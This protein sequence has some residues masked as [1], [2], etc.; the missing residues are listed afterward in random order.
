MRVSE[1]VAPHYEPRLFFPGFIECTV[2]ARNSLE[3]S[4]LR[5][6]LHARWFTLDADCVLLR[7]SEIELSENERRMVAEAVVATGGLFALSDR[8]ALYGAREWE[9]YDDL[10]RRLDHRVRDIHQLFEED[11]EIFW[12]ERSTSFNWEQRTFRARG[13]S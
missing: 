4:L 8:L 5:A 6:P 3:A 9:L 13:T 10:I 2:A 12:A 11:L 1:D 7:P